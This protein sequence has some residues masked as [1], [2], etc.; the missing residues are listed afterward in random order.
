MMAWWSL[1]AGGALAAY[2]WTGRRRSPRPAL[3]GRWV[4]PV[5]TWQGRRPVVSS[6]FNSPRPGLPRH[7][8]VDIMFPRFPNDSFAPGTPNGSK[9]HVMPDGVL[10]LAAS[11][12]VIWSAMPTPR[13]HAV[14]IDHGPR[15][16]AT[17]YAHLE[18]LLVPQA[19]PGHGGQRVRAGEPIGT[20]G[21]SPLDSERLR[22]LHFELWL[23]GPSDRIDPEAIMR[24]WPVLDEPAR[25]NAAL[26]FRPVGASG[27]PYPDWVRDLDGKS[28]VYVIRERRGES[29]EIVYVGESHTDR[30]YDTLTRHFQT[31]R[32][33]AQEVP[34][35]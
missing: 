32:H 4:W 6:G 10:V 9:H 2:L 20:I 34:M 24:T 31:V 3:A 23:G 22:H 27:D 25:R 16:A 30:L 28:G 26:V 18:K 17:F 11:D 1:I 33:E 14:V 13:G 15:K 7:G 21:F 19:T 35:T 5:P 8:G 29:A 12:G